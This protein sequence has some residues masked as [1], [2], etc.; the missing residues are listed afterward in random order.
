[1]DVVSICVLVEGGDEDL[2]SCLSIIVRITIK[3]IETKR[4]KKAVPIDT[5]ERKPARPHFVVLRRSMVILMG[6]MAFEKCF[7]TG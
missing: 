6:S 4:R 1:M 5:V 2:M 3:K 7:A